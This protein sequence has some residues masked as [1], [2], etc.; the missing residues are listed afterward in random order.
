MRNTLRVWKRDIMRLF[1]APAALVVVGALV[2][3]PSLYT[4]FNVIGFWNPYENTGNLRVCVVNE[5]A[6]ASDD[7]MGE[8]RVGDQIVESL[9][10]NDGLGWE[11]VDRDTAESEVMSGKAYAMFIIPENFSRCFTTLLDAD[12]E[13]PKLEYYVNEKNGAV[14]PK[15]TDTGATT[16]DQTVNS[17]FTSAASEA[18]A[19]AVDEALAESRSRLSGSSTTAAKK[20]DE[21]VG[22]IGSARASLSE[23]DSRLSGATAKADE[24]RKTLES[25]K[26]D[27]AL[28]AG[29]LSNVSG[30][31][32]G[33]QKSLAAFWTSTSAVLDESNALASRAANRSNQSVA[34]AANAAIAAQGSVDGAIAEGQAALE[35]ARLVTAE[36]E[37]LLAVMEPGDPGYDKLKAQVDAL[38]ELDGNLE[39]SLE[40]LRAAGADAASTAQSIRS[41]SEQTNE[42]VQATLKASNEFRA[43]MSS[44]VVPSLADSMS[45]IAGTAG[46]LS[47]IVSNQTL[48]VDQANATLGEFA[49]TL[50]SLKDA[51]KSSDVLLANLESG[52][53][54]AK[55]DIT[56]LG[57]TDLFSSLIGK[58]EF[59]SGKIAEFMQSPAQIVT[60][61]PYHLNSYGSAMA[62]L[63]TNLTLWIG[64]FMLLVILK[65]EVDDEGVPNLT[66][67]QRYAAR[68]LFL[69]PIAAGQALVCCIGNLV[70][71]VQTVNP[72]LYCL[73]AVVISLAFLSLQYTLATTMQHIGKGLCIALVFAQIPGA[74]GLYPI[75]MTPPFFQAIYPVFPFTYG[76]SAMRETIGGMYGAQWLDS[77]GILLGFFIAFFVIGLVAIP[78]LTNL[79]RL[80]ARQIRESNIM[81]GEEGQIPERRFRL[82]FILQLLSDHEEYRVQMERRAERFF[83]LYPRLKSATWVF[84]VA[85]PT[86][87]T[88]ALA[89]MGSEKVVT[90]TAW[91]I[92]LVIVIVFLIVLEYLHNSIE[93]QLS[94]GH[95]SSQELQTYYRQRGSSKAPAGSAGAAVQGPADSE[96]GGQDA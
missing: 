6:G 95:M 79:N 16:L 2:V 76:I 19:D 8:L 39:K 36:L 55:T 85:V 40:S 67:R 60:E 41:L 56:A 9:K 81:N 65:Q 86:L 78:Y 1:K 46:E 34:R 4:W 32:T 87:L 54:T 61:S 31:T 26:E 71:G 47:A 5:D 93:R 33:L 88:L 49:D 48:L 82:D 77:M 11:F 52:L 14:A 70:I 24:T 20:L 42:A 50:G 22:S 94:L 21:A 17:T 30:I 59:D 74:T 25:T 18:V 69:A 89:L 91:L 64:V 7:L 73:T 57:A 37:K 27:V 29:A 90:L 66:T 58:S 38:K 51:I 12:R 45:Q 83:Q 44:S 10:E 43:T 62:P 80:F 72:A 3:L 13:Q 53:K 15:I 23:L 28:V 35:Q 96:G 75:E 68:W 92:W 63:F 84:G